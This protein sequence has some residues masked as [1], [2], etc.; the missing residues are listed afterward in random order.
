M[1]ARRLDDRIRELCAIAIE[2]RNPDK[3]SRALSDLRGAIHEY[4]HRLRQRAVVFVE[5]PQN[6]RERR[7]V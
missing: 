4:T 5:A 3:A 7:K 1:S 6:L 2:A